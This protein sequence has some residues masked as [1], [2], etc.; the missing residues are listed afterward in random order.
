MRIEKLAAKL[1][2][3]NIDYAI[4][5]RISDI[6]YLTGFTGS[7]ALLLVRNDGKA[8]F[9]TDRRYAVQSRKEVFNA[10][11]FVYE[12]KPAEII[13]S[14][15]LFKQNGRLAFDP[16]HMSFR[17]YSEFYSLFSSVELVPIEHLL[18]E[19]SAI[20]EAGEL[21]LIK[22]AIKVTETA[23]Y[24]ILQFVAP[25]VSER[26]LAIELEYK[27]KKLGAQSLAFS[28]IVLSGQN[29]A[30]VHGQP[31]DKIIEF[32]DTLLIDVGASYEG[33]CADITRTFAVGRANDKVKEIYNIV[34]EAQN[35]AIA[36]IKDGVSAESLDKAARTFIGSRGY[37]ENFQHS[38]GHGLGGVVHSYPRL[39]DGVKDILKAGMVV[40][41]EPGI[42][43]EGLGG[44]RIE[45]DVLVCEDCAQIL[46]SFPKDE[47]L[48]I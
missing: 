40:T 10:E 41:V 33:Y 47:L 44:V 36:M 21:D 4:V 43:I 17:E 20:K 28:T 37:A 31:S 25:G 11:I 5:K 6:R 46:T 35:K 13:Q 30:L 45:D 29:S 15:T 14:L 8:Y 39:A 23:L 38:L 32:G 24:D 48:V 22:K 19:I 26:D 18:D 42:Y 3:L 34:L 9:F 7:S 12:R 27:I 16:D 1:R 2:M